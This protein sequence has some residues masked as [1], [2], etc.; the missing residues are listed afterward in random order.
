MDSSSAPGFNSTCEACGKDLHCCLNC[1]FYRK[2][3][4]WDCAE[5]V[6]AGVADKERRNFCEWFSTDPRLFKRSEGRSSERSAAE[7]ARSDL[8]RLFGG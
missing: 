5:T 1:R 3:V 4:K 6:D 8:D 2:G 7:Q